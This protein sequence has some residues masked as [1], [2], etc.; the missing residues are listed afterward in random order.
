MILV[1][2]RDCEQLLWNQSWLPLLCL[3]FLFSCA[4]IATS[5][6]TLRSTKISQNHSSCVLSG[7]CCTGA[8]PEAYI[9]S[10][11]RAGHQGI[12]QTPQPSHSGG[13]TSTSSPLPHLPKNAELLLLPQDLWSSPLPLLYLYTLT[14]PRHLYL[15]LVLSTPV[16]PFFHPSRVLSPLSP[17]FGDPT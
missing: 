3:Y 1:H 16:A 12:K 17:C 10:Q 8:Q 7:L 4:F 14:H 9:S 13:L 15:V 2:S 5:P 6:C 11:E